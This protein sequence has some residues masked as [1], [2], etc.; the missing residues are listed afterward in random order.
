M[1]YEGLTLFPAW[2]YEDMKGINP[3]LNH[4]KINLAKDAI[5]VQQRCYRLN[6]NYAAE[7]IKEE[8]DKLLRVIFIRVVPPK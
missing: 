1:G 2:A 3:E 6:P 5:P 4:D 8:I 7:E